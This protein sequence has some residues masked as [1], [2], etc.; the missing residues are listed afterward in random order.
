MKKTKSSVE[1]FGVPLGKFEAW[2]CGN[3]G[4]KIFESQEV[5]RAEERMK[6]LG[7][8][9]VPQESRVYKLGGNLVISIKKKIADALGL[10]K[11][12]RVLLIPEPSQ[13]RLVVEIS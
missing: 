11:N 2:V 1:K 3:C 9:G 4:E 10:T 7:V 5:A 6:Q 8:W 12:S 13:K